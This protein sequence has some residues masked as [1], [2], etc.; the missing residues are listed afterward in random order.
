MSRSVRLLAAAATAAAAL[1]GQLPLGAGA[2]TGNRLITYGAAAESWGVDIRVVPVALREEVQDVTDDA[3]PHTTVEINATPHAFA[4]AAFFD[5]GASARS[6]PALV[7]GQLYVNHAPPVV[8]NYPY[9]ATTTSDAGNPRDVNAGTSANYT[10]E[11]GLP[12]PFST[13]AVPGVPAP[14]GFGTGTATAHADASPKA[15]ATAAVSYDDAGGVSTGSSSGSSTATQAGGVVTAITVATIKDI[16]VAGALHIGSETVTASASVDGSGN[17]KSAGEVTYNDVTV[18][19]Q[20]AT[21]D[22]GG[23]HVQGQNGS[24]DQ[25]KAALA[26]LNAALAQS[27]ASLVAAEAVSSTKSDTGTATSSADGLALKYTDPSN[28]VQV[29]VSLGHAQA[30]AHALT[31]N[32]VASSLAAAAPAAPPA[33]VSVPAAAGPAPPSL[34]GP[35]GSVTL[36]PAAP[37]PATPSRAPASTA[38]AAAPNAVLAALHRRP[39]I[40]P[41]VAGL[42]EVCLLLALLMAGWMRRSPDPTDEEDLLAL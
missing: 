13:V 18:A 34:S 35:A 42:A 16:T 27:G 20:P 7:N 21:I 36:A 4:D 10:P 11:P 6:G 39:L 31:E 29:L 26:Q 25:A 17:Q 12:A 28:T 19:G 1:L 5:P 24:V 14:T 40:L 23:I 30:I 15:V 33:A 9:T 3:T 32:A 2:D 8:P 38:P 41:L 37:A 22:Q